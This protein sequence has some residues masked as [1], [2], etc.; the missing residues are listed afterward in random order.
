MKR[1][2]FSLQSVATVRSLKELRARENLAASL[3]AIEHALL[4]HAKARENREELEHML[5]AGTSSRV[6]A[7]EQVA[8]LGAL[9]VA[10]LAEAAARQT[11][12]TAA[13]ERDR[14][15]TEYHEAARDVKA[16]DKLEARARQRHRLAAE[17]AE[18][19]ALDEWAG[20]A[21]RPGNTP[22]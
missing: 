2:R 18:Q 11:L 10:G 22:S 8:F 13:A 12:A 4:A 9:G 16:M 20:T 21:L 19:N 6:R 1:F 5:R 17:R 3:R 7:G 15:V 14:R